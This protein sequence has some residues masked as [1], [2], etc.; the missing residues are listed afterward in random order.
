[1][2]LAVFL[3]APFFGAGAYYA[4]PSESVADRAAALSLELGYQWKHAMA[5]FAVAGTIGTGNLSTTFVAAKAAW[6]VVDGPVAPM[7]GIGVGAFGQ[8]LRCDACGFS[9][10]GAGSLLER[11]VLLFR[12]VVVSAQ[13]I[14]P[15][16]REQPAV[17]S[18]VASP[19][20]LWLIGVRVLG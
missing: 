10:S 11:G 9:R 7:I 12:H 1:M 15:F 6:I 5:G 19:I 14:G 18:S 16:E 17:L 3:A 8:V 2:I 20:P 13:W 4:R